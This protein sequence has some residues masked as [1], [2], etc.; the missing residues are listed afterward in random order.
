MP[1]KNII[2][3]LYKTEMQENPTLLVN[4]VVQIVSNKAGVAKSTVYKVVKEYRERRTLSEPKKIQNRKSTVELICDFDKNAIRR[5][6]HGFFFKN[7][8]PTID[9]VLQAVNEDGD[10]PNFK[11]TT[12]YKLLKSL[13]FKYEKRGRNSLLID[14]DDIIVWMRE[15]LEKIKVYRNQKRKIYYLDETWVNAGHTKS[16]IW[17]DKTITS[18]KQ[19]FLSG[20]STGLKNPSGKII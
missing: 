15:Y 10:L 11:R 19:A 7:E 17:S 1:E 14:R 2:L 4:E 6:V 5:K 18:S 8:I 16:N 13:N 9:K 3:N 20:L 12:S